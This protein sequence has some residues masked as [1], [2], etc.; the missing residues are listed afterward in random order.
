MV[1]RADTTDSDGHL[2]LQNDD[3]GDF[4]PSGRTFSITKEKTKPKGDQCVQIS[5]PLAVL[6]IRSLCADCLSNRK[7]SVGREFEVFSA[8]AREYEEM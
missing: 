3:S 2:R 7:I 8:P 4:S 5:L 6:S 1:Y